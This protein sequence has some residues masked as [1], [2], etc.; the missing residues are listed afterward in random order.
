MATGYSQS[1]QDTFL[2]ETIFKDFK[3]GTFVDVGAYDEKEGNNTLFFE[4]KF[5]WTGINIEPLPSA[6]E[7][8]KI[9]R[10]KCIN[11]NVAIDKEDNKEKDFI[12]NQGYTAML[13]GLKEY[14]DPRHL[15]RLNRENKEHNVKSETIKVKTRRLDSILGEHKISRIHYL[16]IDVEGAEKIVLGTIDFSKV[17][18]DVIGFENNFFDSSLTTMMPLLKIGYIPFAEKTDILL[19]HQKSPFNPGFAENG[20]ICFQLPEEIQKK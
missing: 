2:N 3:K 13:S 15:E 4:E 9:N 11:L 19:V 8:L 1:G 7:K 10:P 20:Q 14:Y 12:D 6:Y 5:E 16:S 17:V 18:I